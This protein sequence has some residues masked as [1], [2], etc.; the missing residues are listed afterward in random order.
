[1]I[2]GLDLSAMVT[3][4]R[5]TWRG[6][7]GRHQDQFVRDLDLYGIA[8]DGF[9]ISSH[10]GLNGSAQRAL[11]WLPRALGVA[12]TDRLTIFVQFGCRPNEYAEFVR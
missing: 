2:D 9:R 5:G 8:V 4:Y 3:S 12:A 10:G 7:A 11:I 6:G 1:V